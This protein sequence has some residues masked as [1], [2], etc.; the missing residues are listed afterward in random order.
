MGHHQLRASCFLN[1]HGPKRILVESAKQVTAGDDAG[2]LFGIVHAQ[3]G[4]MASDGGIMLRNPLSLMDVSL[5]F[6]FR[7]ERQNSR[8]RLR[9]LGA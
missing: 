5:S 2:K 1:G 3:Q 4:L 9:H 8:A 7:G 6:L